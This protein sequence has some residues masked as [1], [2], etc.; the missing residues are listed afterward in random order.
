MKAKAAIIYNPGDRFV[1]DEVELDELREDEVLVKIEACSICH[2][3][4]YSRTSGL[5]VILPA[6]LG[7][8]GAGIVEKVGSGVTKVKPGDHV[9]LTVPHCGKCEACQREDY[10]NC[11]NT[12]NMQLGRLDRSTRAKDKNGVGLNS[13]FG[14][15]SFCEYS[16]CFETNCV[17]VD[18]DLDLDIIAPI[19]CGMITGAGTV[20][21]FLKVEEGSSI[22]V[23]GCGGTGTAAIM[24]AKLA[25]C[26]TIIGVDVDDDKLE[27]AKQLGATHTINNQRLIE[28]KGYSQ[29][30]TGPDAVFGPLR[31]TLTE[32]IKKINGG[33]GVNYGVCTVPSQ[34]VIDPAALAL[35][36]Y[37]ELCI[38]ASMPSVM[39]P[40]QYMQGNNIRIS[41]CGMGT[42][43]KYKF[44]P[45]LLEQYKK[46]NFPMD[47]LVTFYKFED[48]EQAFEDM[49]SGR[50]IKPVL[51]W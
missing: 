38:T 43:N 4:E 16:V 28:E 29:E 27:I 26:K 14:Q 2:S 50:V 13:Y 49:E 22:V 9:I 10:L 35:G 37:G 44:V 48:M 18:D 1:I 33:K 46:G 23:Y 6:I 24:G 21:E 19:G 15:S 30:V 5:G 45:Y 7:H 36:K 47:K 25:G 12:Y 20:L 42:A 51:K 39:V 31:Y 8:E 34:E 3:D 41:S 11:E 32:E 40:A 17:K